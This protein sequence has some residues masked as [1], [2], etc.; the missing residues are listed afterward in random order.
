MNCFDNKGIEFI[1]KINYL[2]KRKDL[3]TCDSLL[4]VL[5]CIKLKK[6]YHLGLWR[7]RNVGM[8]DESY[9]YSYFGKDDPLNDVKTIPS[10]FAEKPDSALFEPDAAFFKS[11]IVKPSEMG[12]W[13]VYLLWMAPTIMPTFWHGGYIRRKYFI[14]NKPIEF[15]PNRWE[16]VPVEIPAEQIPQTAVTL[17]GKEAVVSCSYW[18]DWEGLVLESTPIVF[19]PDGSVVLKKQSHKVLYKYKCGIYF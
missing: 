17:N 16:G 9:L 13:Q 5:D 2:V 18:S 12:A 10:Q 3:K 1:D 4:K 11:L 8:G 15:F 7:A 6:G 14:H 19:K